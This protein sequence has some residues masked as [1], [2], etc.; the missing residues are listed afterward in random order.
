M[1]RE[2]EKAFKILY[3]EYKRRR[4]AGESKSDAVEF[5]DTSV[6]SIPAFRKWL[7][8]DINYAVQELGDAKYVKVDILGNI[9]LQESGIEYM[10]SKP[11]EYFQGLK[12]F[13]NLGS[14]LGFPRI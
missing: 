12:D 9:T 11:K 4:K 14:I 2:T 5:E 10:E 8:A 1:T 3:C 7:P 6:G 13:F